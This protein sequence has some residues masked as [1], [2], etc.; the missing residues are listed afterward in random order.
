M[1]YLVSRFVEGGSRRCLPSGTEFGARVDRTRFGVTSHLDGET[2]K[3][4]DTLDRVRHIAG[5]IL[6]G[7]LRDREND[8]PCVAQ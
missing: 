1:G 5:E 4:M 3:V 8:D 6:D 7:Q 2:F